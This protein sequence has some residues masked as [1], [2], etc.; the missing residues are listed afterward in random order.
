[1]RWHRLAKAPIDDLIGGLL[2]GFLMLGLLA[3]IGIREGV[4]TKAART[5]FRIGEAGSAL[6]A[7]KWELFLPVFVVGTF[8]GGVATLVETAPIAAL[9]TVFVQRY[10]TRDLPSW[11]D[12]FKV[13]ADW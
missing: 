7:A 13:A 11:R 2:P 8:V 4:K 12:V 6:W 9:Y 10:V 3:A 1:M 5:P